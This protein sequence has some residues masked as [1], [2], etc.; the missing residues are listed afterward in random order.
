MQPPAENTLLTL[1]AVRQSLA[2]HAPQRAPELGRPA[3]VLVPLF[4]R[5]G[6]LFV[7]LTRRTTDLSSHAGQISFPGGKRDP[8]D[9]DARATALREAYE[10]I[11]LP[12]LQVEVIG[13]LDDCPTF[14]TNFVITP[15]VGVIPDR[16]PLVT[17]VREIA[18]VIEVP[19]D[20][21][22]VPGALKTESH[23]RD[24]QP[25]MLMYYSVAG[26]VVWGATARILTQLFTLAGAN[27]EA[28]S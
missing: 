27:I 28:S 13:E 3:A 4:E 5:D 20:D 23:E 8:G 16:Y 14:V 12:P 15:I 11:G 22:L 17:S 24:G 9:A 10:E 21:F 7:L 19:V 2:S 1:A 25:Y 6:R 26:E 18:A